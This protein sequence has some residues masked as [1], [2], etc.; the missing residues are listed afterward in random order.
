MLGI[1]AC[2]NRAFNGSASDKK[3]EVHQSDDIQAVAGMFPYMEGIVE[4]KWEHM[5]LGN[6][7]DRAAG[8]TDYKY[9]GYIVLNKEAAE[10][11]LSSYEWKGSDPDVNFESVEERE[12]SWKYS[13]DFCREVIPGY[14]EG[15]VWL[16]G[17]TILFCVRT[18]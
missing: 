4:S 7:D 8:P 12:G 15:S 14:Y 6:G 13:H 3:Q 2:F 11:Y 18:T 17:N 9:Q 16:N 1:T 5:S 10:K